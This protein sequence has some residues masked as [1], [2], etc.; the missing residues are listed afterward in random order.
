[1]FERLKRGRELGRAT[2]A[3]LTGNPR[4]AVFPV[5]SAVALLALTAA[6]GGPMLAVLG[7][8]R[9]TASNGQVVG[10]ILGALVWYFGCAF[11]IVFCNAAL[12]S[13]AS[14]SFAGESPSVS[15]GFAAAG[16]RLPQ[17]LGWSALACTVGLAFRML[18]S[19]SDKIDLLGQIIE[20][21][22]EGAWSVVTYFALPVVV[23]E[24]LGPVG[25]VKRSSA[26]LRAT[27]G[28]MVGSSVGIGLRLGLFALPLLGLI[29]LLASGTGGHAVRVALG[30]IVAVYV[31]AFAVVVAALGTILRAALYRYAVSGTASGPL[32]PEL[33]QS[34]FAPR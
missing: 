28:E 1:M 31:A 10:M 2:L 13:C 34:A 29:A 11:I 4:L 25:A 32:S 8:D 18:D 6:V 24:G 33:L 19:L 14:Q 15:S 17:I 22:A 26:I 3:V 5:V 30:V 20:G 21:L 7:G 27:W 23:V 12:I 16:K 9:T